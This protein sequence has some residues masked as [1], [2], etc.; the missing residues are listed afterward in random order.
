M[1]ENTGAWI[2]VMIFGLNIAAMVGVWYGRS[3]E[4]DEHHQ[5]MIRA[6]LPESCRD[7]L[8]AAARDMEHE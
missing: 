4:R 1:D 7:E 8:R 3:L 2:L 6:D 5:V